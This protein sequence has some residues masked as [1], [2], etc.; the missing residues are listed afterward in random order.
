[1]DKV[2]IDRNYASIKH[3][4]SGLDGHEAVENAHNEQRNDDRQQTGEQNMTLFLE[5][6]VAT[7]T[8]VRLY[9]EQS[10]SAT[11]RLA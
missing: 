7:D 6:F 8:I 11:L 9:N 3:L 1:M 5:Q 4:F 10:Q 2:N